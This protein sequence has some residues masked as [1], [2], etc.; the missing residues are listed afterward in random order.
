M[1]GPC[2]YEAIGG[3][4]ALVAV[5]DNLYERILADVRLSGFF[6]GAPMSRL[7]G[8]QVEFFGQALGGPM[9]YQGASMRQAHVGRGID[10]EHFELVAGHLTDSLR[11][12]GVPEPTITEII[13]LVAPLAGDIVSSS[14]LETA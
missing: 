13:G 11:A 9:T 5:V 6:A 14:P 7:K 12:A 4:A 1:T 2:I 10:M 3:E 8:R